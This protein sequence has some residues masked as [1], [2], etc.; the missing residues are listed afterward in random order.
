LGQYRITGSIGLGGMGA[1]YRAEHTLLGRAAAVKVL[2][3][4]LSQNQEMVTRFFNEARAAAAIQHPNIVEIYDFG[5]DTDGSAYLVMEYLQGE[6]LAARLARGR[7]A[8]TAVMTIARQI[9]GALAAAHQRNIVHRDLKPDNIFL[10]PD[11]DVSGG[12]RIK[13]LDFGIA[14][15]LDDSAQ[16]RM[17]RPGAI[18]GTPAYMAPEQVRGGAIDHRADLYSLGCIM[19]E[20]CTGRPPFLGR[21]VSDV[22]VA[23]VHTP[24]P[25]VSSLVADVP[26]ELEM[27]IQQLLAKDLAH[28]MPSA[29]AVVQAL[30]A[31]TG[32]AFRTGP[33]GA[34]EADA[35][36]RPLLTT[37]SAATGSGG[38][39]APLIRKRRMRFVVLWIVVA[40]VAVIAAVAVGTGLRWPGRHA[41]PPDVVPE[42]VREGVPEGVQ[43]PPP[44]R[45]A[46]AFVAPRVPAD[47]FTQEIAAMPASDAGG[48][49]ASGSSGGHAPAATRPSIPVGAG[50][51]PSG[52]T[53]AQDPE[54]LSNRPPSADGSGASPASSS[55]DDQVATATSVAELYADVG[56]ALK[57][58]DQGRGARVT[59]ELWPLFRRIRINDVIADPAKRDETAALLH[60]LRDQ[61][62]ERAR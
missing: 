9:A 62:T 52:T 36:Q 7:M 20:L 32:P 11:L 5:W 33:V 16:G 57:E 25:T 46:A 39:G 49:G 29:E 55:P 60:R 42:G 30:D 4:E 8:V 48:S 13:L 50:A 43:S 22:L 1:V 18:L 21:N 12:D 23:Q 31:A 6:S 27:V 61:I 47:A 35:P 45:P 38:P 10:V 26:L 59:A 40:V 34:G 44:P 58:L 3:P 15:L 17:T 24:P 51:P 41:S 28:R 56:Q 19:F 2:L 54:G 53:A 37:L 14:K